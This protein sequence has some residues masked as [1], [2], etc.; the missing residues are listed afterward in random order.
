MLVCVCVYKDVCVYV[1]VCL[2]NSR[3]DNK[4]AQINKKQTA[5]TARTQ[6]NP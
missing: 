5:K 1:G 3:N 2:C 4:K 6:L